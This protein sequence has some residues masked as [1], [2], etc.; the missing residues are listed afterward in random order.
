MSWVLAGPRPL[1]VFVQV[2][3]RETDAQGDVVSR[4]MEKVEMLRGVDGIVGRGGSR[5]H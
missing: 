3:V 1:Y 2:A 4:D 5:S